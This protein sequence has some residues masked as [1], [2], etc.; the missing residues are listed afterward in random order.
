M[1]QNDKHNL[2]C[3]PVGFSF[4]VC[5]VTGE[6][7]F[8]EERGEEG[9]WTRYHAPLSPV[10]FVALADHDSAQPLLITSFLD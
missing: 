4:R 9:K 7:D 6:I 10:G 2:C 3:F 1:E 8:L 5:P